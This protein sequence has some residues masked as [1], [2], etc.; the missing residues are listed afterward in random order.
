MCD[1]RPEALC[2]QMCPDSEISFRNEN[3]LVHILEMDQPFAERDCAWCERDGGGNIVVVADNRMMQ[4]MARN[5]DRYGD[6]EIRS[7]WSKSTE[8]GGIDDFAMP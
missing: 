6:E 1:K 5:E 4:A 8:G 2:M 7:K 3:G